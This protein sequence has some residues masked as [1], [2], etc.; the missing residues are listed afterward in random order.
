[1]DDHCTAGRHH[2]IGFLWPY[3]SLV[4]EIDKVV[5]P[6]FERESF[7]NEISVYMFHVICHY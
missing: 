4:A 5:L 3:Q 6:Q 2:C 7:Y 1:M